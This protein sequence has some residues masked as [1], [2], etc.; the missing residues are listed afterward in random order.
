M[1]KA[2]DAC[3][4]CLVTKPQKLASGNIRYSSSIWALSDDGEVR[5][6]QK[7]WFYETCWTTGT[8]LDAV[9]DDGEIVP[10]T[11]WDNHTKIVLRLKTELQYH[12]VSPDSRPMRKAETAWVNYVFADEPSILPRF[13]V[14]TGVLC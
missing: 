7:S 13:V 3:R 8:D 1:E 14:L 4:I 6:E 9:P 5:L 12:D 10:Y 11:V 2:C